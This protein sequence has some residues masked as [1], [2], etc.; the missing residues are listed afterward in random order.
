MII[1]QNVSLQMYL[2]GVGAW[3]RVL[4]R[5]FG[6]LSLVFEVSSFGNIVLGCNL[7]I[8]IVP[9]FGSRAS[10]SVFHVSF[11]GVRTSCFVF[12]YRVS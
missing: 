8:A 5:D 10:G 4:G 7:I 2:T 11:F 3:C 9:N 12:E 1:I 6:G